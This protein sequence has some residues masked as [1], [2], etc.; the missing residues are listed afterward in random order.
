MLIPILTFIVLFL[1]WLFSLWFYRRQVDDIKKRDIAVLEETAFLRK[2]KKVFALTSVILALAAI[3][4][5]LCDMGW[6]T[7][8]YLCAFLVFDAVM[9]CEGESI[10]CEATFREM[11]N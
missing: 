11:A 5:F 7:V 4:P 3:P 8:P 9:L 1:V 10:S 2:E 6:W